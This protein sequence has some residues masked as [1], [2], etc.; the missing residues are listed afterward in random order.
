MKFGFRVSL[1]PS[2]GLG[3][4]ART[5]RLAKKLKKLGIDS[6][7]VLDSKPVAGFIDEFKSFVV[8]SLDENTDAIKCIDIFSSEGVDSVVLDSYELGLVWQKNI[9][10]AAAPVGNPRKRAI[11]KLSIFFHG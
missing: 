6:V 3:H 10:D 11:T 9:R 4:L 2:S 7:F 8:V 1:K 5:A